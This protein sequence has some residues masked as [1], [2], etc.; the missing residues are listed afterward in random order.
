L[1]SGVVVKTD[2]NGYFTLDAQSDAELLVS[3]KGLKVETQLNGVDNYADIVLIPNEKKLKRLI[4]NE[5]SIDKCLAYL[6]HYPAGKYLTE[7]NII[8]EEQRFI[9]AFDAAVGTYNL[10]QLK[11][12]IQLYPQGQYAEKASKTID[13]VSWQKAK[14][15][16]TMEAYNTYLENF[17][18]G[19]A[20][21]LAK[22]RMAMLEE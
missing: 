18:N 1:E 10:A 20:A 11:S 4:E 8:L 16:N 2:V 22:S 15:Q 13:I 17:P 21:S 12:Y 14:S 19:E 3:Y 5:P 6:E 9:S 7:V